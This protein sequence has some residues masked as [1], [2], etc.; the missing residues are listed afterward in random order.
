MHPRRRRAISSEPVCCR[1]SIKCCGVKMHSQAI[2]VSPR[3]LHG[4]WR[5]TQRGGGGT[6]QAPNTPCRG[7]AMYTQLTSPCAL[8]GWPD[9]RVRTHRLYWDSGS[10]HRAR[11]GWDRV[12]ARELQV[13]RFCAQR[14]GRSVLPLSRGPQMAELRGTSSPPRIPVPVCLGHRG[15][16][17]RSVWP[18]KGCQDTRP[19]CCV[20]D[21][22]SGKPPRSP[23]RWKLPRVSLQAGAWV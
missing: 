18:W 23:H 11:M 19:W 5:D 12:T 6:I 8:Q 21:C 22:K 17:G 3:T 20:Q 15:P 4:A 1:K 10:A 13:T 7:A 16:V 14:R 9:T 2:S